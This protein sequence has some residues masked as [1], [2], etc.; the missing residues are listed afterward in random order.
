MQASLEQSLLR[1]AVAAKS[2]VFGWLDRLQKSHKRHQQRHRPTGFGY[3]LTDDIDMVRPDHWDAVVAH[4]SMCLGRPYLGTLARFGPRGVSYRQALIYRGRQPI[5]AVSTQLIAIAASQVVDGIDV[6]TGL[7]LADATSKLSKAALEKLR[8]RVMVCGDLLT[9]GRCG[10]AFVPDVDPGDVWPAVAEA[11][12]RMRRA[13]RLQGQIDYVMVKDFPEGE[14]GL[15]ALHVYSYRPLVTEPDMVLTLQQEWGGYDDYLKSLKTKYRKAA[16]KLARQVEKAGCVIEP[17][18]DLVPHAERLYQ[19]YQQV[20]SRASVRLASMTPDFLP[21]LA[22]ALGPEL[23]RCSVIRRG[24][25]ILGFATTLRD[26]TRA[27]GFYLG[28]DYTTNETVPLY[29]R[30]LQA[31]IAD[32]I[33]LGGDVLSLGRTALEPKARLGAQ[34][35]PQQIWVRH[36]IPLINVVVRELLQVIPHAEAPERSPFKTKPSGGD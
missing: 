9:W 18:S 3:A 14:P 31:V 33:S 1:F 23:F 20:E 7:P 34:P 2:G 4:G 25:E 16:R 29:L 11:L 26:R 21:Q 22:R 15:D 12:Y 32:G 5:A 6:D 17:L 13:D 24:D 10:V 8:P 30:L 27:V 36:R 28:F 35:R 19:L